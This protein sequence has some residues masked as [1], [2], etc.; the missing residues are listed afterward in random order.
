[1][2]TITDI[3]RETGLSV[4]T[5]SM[6]LNKTARRIPLETQQRV[7]SEARRLGYSPN[8][9]ARSLRSR[10]TL[11]IG[12]MIF[13]ITDPYC[14]MILRGIEDSLHQ[15]GYMPVLTDLQNDSNRLSQCTQMLTGRRVEGLIAILNPMYSE[16]VILQAVGQFTVPKVLIGRRMRDDAFASVT[17]DNETGTRLALQ[18][19]YDLGH[20][21]IAFVKG[22]AAMSDSAPRWKGI[23]NFAREVGLRIRNELVLEIR[24]NNSS[25]EEGIEVTRALLA[26]TRPFTA[27][28]AFDDLTAFAAIGVLSG[29]GR[30][31][32][33][34]CSVVGFDDIPGAA[35]Y[36]P[37]LTTVRQHLQ[38]QGSLGA[39]MMKSLL[40]ADAERDNGSW[41]RVVAPRL[42]VRSS[43]ATV[44]N[45]AVSVS[46]SSC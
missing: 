25:Y 17:V 12:V 16:S 26:S 42:I 3:A 23:T 15:A 36:N 40:S 32:P 14:T 43:T 45:A 41:H 10:R 9:Q 22:P 24:G 18:H 39:E 2:V 35:Y 11:N 5:V 1:M 28:L 21:E 31:V 27:L 30:S 4:A 20:R 38:D 33:S 8:L 34:S 46:T 7:E 29:A 44:S 6:V 37:P 13:D 19:L